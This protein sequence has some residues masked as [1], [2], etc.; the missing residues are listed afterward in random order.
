MHAGCG[1]GDIRRIPPHSGA[2]SLLVRRISPQRVRPISANEGQTLVRTPEPDSS[3]SGSESGKS[4]TAETL[5]QWSVTFHYKRRRLA[6]TGLPPAGADWFD[7]S[8]V[9]SSQQSTL[10]SQLQQFSQSVRCSLSKGTLSLSEPLAAVMAL[11]KMGGSGLAPLFVPCL[12]RR[13]AAGCMAA[14]AISIE[15]V[16]LT[17]TLKEVYW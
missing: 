3:E 17:L 5:T 9:S 6:A 15:V 12:P 16:T 8:A 13:R 1:C 4:P 11:G 10:S 2:N 14:T 7:W